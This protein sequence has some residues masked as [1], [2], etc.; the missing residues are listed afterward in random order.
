MTY[1][2]KTT[3]VE[4]VVVNIMTRVAILLSGTAIQSL[5]AYTLLPVGAWR[6][7][8]LCT[9]RRIPWCTAHS[10]VRTQEHSILSWRNAISVSQGVSASLLIC[11]L[12]SGLATVLAI[13]LINSEFAFFRK[14]DSGS[15]YLSLGLLPLI[16]FARSVQHQLAG[17]RRFLRLGLFSLVR[18]VTNGLA[19]LCLVLGLR[20]GVDGAILAAYVS[21]L[22]MIAICL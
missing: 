21:H 7:R 2:S 8:R 13:P 16:A 10:G 4:D 19:L 9:I 20:L 14:A 15:F 3:G 6:I 1:S 11:L 5:L 22:V 18:T 17:L 12:G